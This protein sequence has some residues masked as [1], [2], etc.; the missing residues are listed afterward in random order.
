MAR[1]QKQGINKAAPSL[2][3]LR[4]FCHLINADKV[5]GTHRLSAQIFYSAEQRIILADQG[6]LAREQGILSTGFE[7]NAGLDF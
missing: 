6:I 2:G 4:R 7:I 1:S 3:Q 5:F